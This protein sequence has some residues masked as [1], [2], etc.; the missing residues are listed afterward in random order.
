MDNSFE[1][2]YDIFIS[3]ILVI[4]KKEEEHT[5]KYECQNRIGAGFIIIINGTGYF[6]T[7]DYN[8]QLKVGDV[9]IVDKEDKYSI[10]A[11]DDDFSYVTMAFLL[12]S[13]QRFRTYNIPY[14]VNLDYENFLEPNLSKLLDIWK[15]RKV[16]YKI[17]ARYILDKILVE[18]TNKA[19]KKSMP[20]EK[21]I[22]IYDAIN[23][24]NQNYTNKIDLEELAN[25]YGYSVSHFRKKF[26]EYLNISPKQ[27]IEKIRV[28]AAKEMLYSGMISIQ[29]IAEQLG[30]YD[31]Y[32]FS[33]DFKKH[34]G[35]SPKQ[36][37][38][39][40]LKKLPDID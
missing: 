5:F 1:R 24:I 15:K 26:N 21:Y 22:K 31:I 6:N 30:F 7:K 35:M 9:V 14:R 13:G 10:G 27:Y 38:K 28:E 25:K 33:K 20:N 12:G 32:H 36:Y 16:N 3:D 34:V 29:E 11:N 40:L 17:E 19:I 8:R 18:I 2:T 37:Q 4:I 23:Y 39:T